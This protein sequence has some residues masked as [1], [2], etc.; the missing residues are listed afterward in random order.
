MWL[1]FGQ[2]LK[3]GFTFTESVV[4]VLNIKSR[5]SSFEE[6]QHFQE[7]QVSE[8][9]VSFSLEN[10]INGMGKRNKQ[11]IIQMTFNQNNVRF[12]AASTEPRTDASEFEHFPSVIPNHTYT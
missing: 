3:I 5:L 1:N 4:G 7:N 2:N 12:I 6:Q 8:L 10:A 11:Q 9:L